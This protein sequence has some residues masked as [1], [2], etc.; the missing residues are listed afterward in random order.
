MKK[1]SVYWLFILII[2]II[3][4]VIFANNKNN[5]F[6]DEIYS[7]AFANSYYMPTYLN[8]DYYNVMLNEEF[9]HNILTVQEFERFDIK[10]VIYNIQTDVHPPLY[11]I[12]LHMISSFF[13]DILSKWIGIIPNIVFFIINQ[14]L[15]LA[16]SK[17]IFKNIDFEKNKIF[18]LLPCIFYGFSLGTINSVLFIRMYML[19]S[20]WSIL[21]LYLNIRLFENIN[22]KQDI[23][24]ILVA[25]FLTIVLGILTQYIYIIYAGLIF[26]GYTIFFIKN[27]YYNEWKKYLLTNIFSII[28]T[29]LI[30]PKML[31]QLMGNNSVKDITNQKSIID[32]VI[33]FKGFLVILSNEFFG[34]VLITGILCFILLILVYFVIK[35]KKILNI[36]KHI[37]LSIVISI[38]FVIIISKVAPYVMNRYLF[39]IYPLI[40]IAFITVLYNLF[41]QILLKKKHIIVL[42]LILIISINISSYRFNNITYKD[43]DYI[44]IENIID[45]NDE[46]IFVNHLAMWHP[47]IMLLAEKTKTSYMLTEDVIID[48]NNNKNFSNYKRK[49]IYI[50]KKCKLLDKEILYQLNK[51]NKYKNINKVYENLFGKIYL[52]E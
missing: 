33:A 24:N 1:L 35:N 12:I 40:S 45:K 9:W 37:V 21:L 6:V 16:I 47:D 26:I 30:Y 25:I 5:F 3:V 32:N 4:I 29:Y 52:L 2:Q 17:K 13:P 8:S 7:F 11:Y 46:F 44:K 23:K 31:M 22:N 27:K 43:D 14:V 10:S 20:L 15:I 50:S 38:C 36:N 51:N 19:L 34:G 49:W 18:I 28:T 42:F 41:S 48:F 39:I